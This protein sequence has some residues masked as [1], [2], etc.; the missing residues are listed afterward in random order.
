[1]RR[2]ALQSLLFDRG[3][4]AT[5]VLGVAMVAALVFSLA[6]AVHH[7]GSAAH[8]ADGDA[9]GFWRTEDGVSIVEIRACEESLCGFLVSFPPI[10]GEPS[11]NDELCNFQILGGFKKG[12]DGRWVDGWIVALE[13]EAVYQAALSTARPE[14]LKVRAY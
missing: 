9:T 3:K 14:R 11:L 10:P 5:S 12:G 7:A 1:M 4:L 13:E 2:I 8:A 6:F